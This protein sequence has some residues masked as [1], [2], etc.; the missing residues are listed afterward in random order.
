VRAARAVR[1]ARRPTYAEATNL[2]IGSALATLTWIAT[3]GSPDPGCL[4]VTAPYSGPNQWVDLEAPVF[5]APGVDWT[6]KTLHARIKLDSSS[7]FSGSARL[8]VKTGASYF[9]Y[10]TTFTPY[11]DG[12][13]WQEFVLPLVSPAPV[14][15]AIAGADPALAVTYGV[16]PIAA[17]APVV[18]P[19]A[20]TFY[21]DSFSIE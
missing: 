21:V 9:F 19:T 11:P 12:A 14:P 18:A 15:P 13:G 2:A 10:P 5:P 3:D 6:G 16:D 8:Y 17:P 1:A 7:S 4:K 20:V